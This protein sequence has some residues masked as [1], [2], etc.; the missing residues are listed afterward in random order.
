MTRFESLITTT[1]NSFKVVATSFLLASM[2]LQASA[3]AQETVVVK[4]EINL[5]EDFQSSNAW[6]RDA[7]VDRILDS[8][9]ADIRELIGILSSEDPKRFSDETK[10]SSAYLLG[11][12]RAVEAIPVLRELEMPEL[13]V[14]IE[15]NNKMGKEKVSAKK[16]CQEPNW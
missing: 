16:R 4:K 15:V 12:I 11:R 10:L 2:F 6:V 14:R 1:W 9:A 8:R 3:E 5:Q 13:S 7:A